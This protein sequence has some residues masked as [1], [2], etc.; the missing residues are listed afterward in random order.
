MPVEELRATAL[1][2]RGNKY[3]IMELINKEQII[4]IEQI[5]ENYSY[6]AVK[7]NFSVEDLKEIKLAGIEI[8]PVSAEDLCIYLTAESEGGIDDVFNKK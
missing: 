2:L 5:E 4:H 3:S 1:G 7:N 8:L 6:V